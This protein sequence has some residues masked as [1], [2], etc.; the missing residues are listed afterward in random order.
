MTE[1]GISSSAESMGR[2]I[3]ID[4]ADETAPVEIDAVKAIVRRHFPSCLEGVIAGLSACATLLLADIKNCTA[5]IYVGPASAGKT[6]IAE[7]FTEAKID[8]RDLVYVSDE[9]TAAAF[10][11]CA[12]QKTH[13]DLKKIDLLPKIKHRVLV[14]PELAPV[15]RGK[16]VDL[17]TKF[18]IITRV[19]DGDGLR[20]DS[21]SQGGRGYRGDYTFA[22]LGC[23][24]PFDR[25]VWKVMAQLGSRLFFLVLETD[26][27]D[28]EQSLV[29]EL[30]SPNDYR[31]RHAE[32]KAA[33]SNYL[34]GLFK[35]NG[36]VR[37]VKWDRLQDDPEARAWIARCGMLLAQTRGL[38][39]E[40]DSEEPPSIESPKRATQVVYNL[41]RGHAIINGRHALRMEDVPLVARIAAS[42]MPTE[43]SRVVK[44]MVLAEKDSLTTSEVRD[45]LGVKTDDTARSV[46]KDLAHLGLVDCKLGSP[47]MPSSIRFNEKWIWC[48]NKEF[49]EMLRPGTPKNSGVCLP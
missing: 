30:A 39:T 5:L 45:A 21:G 1:S 36:G 25:V 37:G 6:T 31:F 27:F 7:M 43:R 35:S 17:I 44:A 48:A 23:T 46:M 14:T 3:Q 33:V 41:A 9:F 13:D 8:G 32:C 19:L 28:D 34:T 22:W 10:V 16:E 24:T 42:S 4:G 38:R 47:G 2:A 20:R 12:A 26:G 49:Q 11:S 18:S 29:A 40:T 15:F